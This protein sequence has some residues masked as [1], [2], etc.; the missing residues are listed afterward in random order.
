[1]L[2]ACPLNLLHSL[3]QSF[4]SNV[5]AQVTDYLDVKIDESF[6]YLALRFLHHPGVTADTFDRCCVG[7]WSL[8]S[9]S[10][11]RHLEIAIPTLIWNVAGAKANKA[12][13]GVGVRPRQGARL[14]FLKDTPR[15]SLDTQSILFTPMPLWTIRPGRSLQCDEMRQHCDGTLVKDQSKCY[16]IY[17]A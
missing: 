8:L 13:K 17:G 2:A 4:L 10:D 5:L 3:L 16:T 1:M 12:K 15:Q 6:Q 11:E 9:P 7:A 14:C